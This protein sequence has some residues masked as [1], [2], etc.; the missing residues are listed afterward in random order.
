M[1][2]RI[3]KI[4]I[5]LKQNIKLFDRV[6]KSPPNILQHKEPKVNTVKPEVV[7]EVVQKPVSKSTCR[8]LFLS[9]DTPI[10]TI[11]VLDE[12]QNVKSDFHCGRELLVSEMKY[13]KEYLPEEE[14][15]LNEIDI[16][17]HCDVEIF[18]WLMKWVKRHET[19]AE[20]ILTAENIIPGTHPRH[21]ISDERK[22]M[23]FS[24]VRYLKF[25]LYLEL[26]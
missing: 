22:S 18:G 13:F 1:S 20:F 4:I 5:T 26:N 10:V 24:E 25:F 8:S 6:L 23:Y 7:P 11:H 16:S 15:A 3:L 21:R 12:G 14:S 19:P 17:V 9:T 2:N